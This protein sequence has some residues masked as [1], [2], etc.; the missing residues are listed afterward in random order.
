[1]PDVAEMFAVRSQFV[2]PREEFLFRTSAGRV[3]PFG[4]GWQTLASPF[5][6]SGRVIPGDL[7]RR[8]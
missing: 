6:V 5:G 1:M 8:V 7:D 4:F 2:S 3:F